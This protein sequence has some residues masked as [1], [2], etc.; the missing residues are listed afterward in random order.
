MGTGDRLEALD[1]FELAFKHG[2]KVLPPRELRREWKKPVSDVS[3]VAGVQ[4]AVGS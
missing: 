2:A 4:Q 3:M 1:A